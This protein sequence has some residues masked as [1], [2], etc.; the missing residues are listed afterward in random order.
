MKRL[1]IDTEFFVVGSPVKLLTDIDLGGGAVCVCM[2]VR[3]R[4]GAWIREL[5][6]E[7]VCVYVMVASEPCCQSLAYL[8]KPR[9]EGPNFSSEGKRASAP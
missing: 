2:C 1:A 5:L 7:G 4:K 6:L 9:R 8:C 3:Q